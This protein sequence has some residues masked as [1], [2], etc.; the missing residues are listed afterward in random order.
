MAEAGLCDE[1]P[2]AASRSRRASASRRLGRDRRTSGTR[3]ARK[4][5]AKAASPA[6]RQNGDRSSQ[7]PSHEA[8]RK[9]R[10]TASARQTSGQAR[11]HNPAACDC[12]TSRSSRLRAAGVFG[13]VIWVALEVVA[14][15]S[16]I[17]FGLPRRGMLQ[18]SRHVSL[19]WWRRAAI[20]SNRPTCI[21]GARPSRSA[22]ASQRFTSLRPLKCRRFRNAKPVT[23]FTKPA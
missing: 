12:D 17:L 13:A 22:L 19:A 18:A 9:A 1:A 16:S 10:T 3:A 5:R 15:A 23:T 4:A 2:S 20:G 8:A 11:S 7:S 21:A 6:I 14:S